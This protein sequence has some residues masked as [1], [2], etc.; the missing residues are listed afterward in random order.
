MP[1]YDIANVANEVT[2]FTWSPLLVSYSPR[3]PPAI[4]TIAQVLHGVCISAFGVMTLG[5]VHL[6]TAW[7]CRK[8]GMSDNAPQKMQQLYTILWQGSWNEEHHLRLLENKVQQCRASQESIEK[9]NHEERR[10]Q[11]VRQKK[12][13]EIQAHPLALQG[14]QTKLQTL[15]D[16]DQKMQQSISHVEHTFDKTR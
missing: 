7:R 5:M 15:Q 8:I 4:R 13:E 1:T 12:Q 2:Y 11:T 9:L 3:I 16:Y 10:L 6:W 14:L